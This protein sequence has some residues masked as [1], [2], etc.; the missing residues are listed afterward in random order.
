MVEK[1]HNFLSEPCN[2]IGSDRI[3]EGTLL[4]SKNNSADPLDL[5]VLRCGDKVCIERKHNLIHT[6][7]PDEDENEDK[8][9]DIWKRN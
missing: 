9:E 5:Q 4:I 7:Y 6:Y 2:Y 3:E 1:T 8:E